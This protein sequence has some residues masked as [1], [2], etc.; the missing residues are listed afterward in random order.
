MATTKATTQKTTAGAKS[1]LPGLDLK[2]NLAEVGKEARKPL[3]AYVGA[4]DFAVQK[5][6]KLPELYSGARTNYATAVKELP[7]SLRSTLNDLSGRATELYSDFAQRGEKL[8]TTIRRQPTAE[9]A[10]AEAKTAVRQTRTA[11]SHATRSARA[12]GKAAEGAANKVG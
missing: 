10:A 2:L 8:V 9:K 7:S 6:R 1:G 12:A 3:Y 5:L 11:A 4:S